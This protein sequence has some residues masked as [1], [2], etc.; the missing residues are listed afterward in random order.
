M[1]R[2]VVDGP[3]SLASLTNTTPSVSV[4]SS[5]YSGS[6]DITLWDQPCEKD[7]SIGL[8]DTLASAIVN[9]SSVLLPLAVRDAL[10]CNLPPTIG[11][12]VTGGK[13]TGKSHVLNE[14][15]SFFANNPRC[16]VY[17]ETLRCAD[18]SE[19]ATL[20]ILNIL[21]EAFQRAEKFSPSIL[22]LDDLDQICSSGCDSAA[23][24]TTGFDGKAGLIALHLRR[25]LQ[26][27]LNRVNE[28]YEAAKLIGSKEIHKRCFQ[29]YS[30]GGFCVGN[31][32]SELESFLCYHVEEIISR[33][34][35][36][37]VFVVASAVSIGALQSE[38]TAHPQSLLG[39]EIA[40]QPLS[41][42]ARLLL[43]RTALEKLGNPCDLEG[44]KNGAARDELLSLMEGFTVVDVLN[45]AKRISAT[46]YSQSTFGTFES[47]YSPSRPL[48]ERFHV[49]LQEIFEASKNF[50]PISST[51]SNKL[52]E[53][54][55][56]E[57]NAVT[58]KDIGGFESTKNDVL[59]VLRLPT[60]FQRL[61]RTVPVRL[62]RGILLYGPPGCG[63]TALAQAA[64]SEFGR[65]GFVCV[66]G[67]Q[68][69]DKYIGE[70]EK[71]F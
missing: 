37:S 34:Q 52:K 61:Y 60:I 36:H 55:N 5:H 51:L 2:I 67:P 31:E 16:V 68:L 27:L 29:S 65:D 4:T 22:C 26:R 35:F 17:S 10:V 15:A 11:L 23:G 48:K 54:R 24:G 46:A 42:E 6:G 12:T 14:L 33:A 50:T 25:L 39:K 32:N 70:S 69:L 28:N 40:I 63:K 9:I 19:K 21:T 44:L 7:S 59:S 47:I 3:D 8:E 41:G 43:L 56:D 1:L 45:F 64:G 18:F 30:S 66:R 38:L 49:R 58:W 53:N 57:V 20:D 13:G 62:P 71:A